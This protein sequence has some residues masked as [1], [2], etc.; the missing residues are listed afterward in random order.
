MLLTP[1]QLIFQSGRQPRTWLALLPREVQLW[2]GH[3]FIPDWRSMECRRYLPIIRQVPITRWM[4]WTARYGTAALVENKCFFQI[5]LTCLF[6]AVSLIIKN[7]TVII[8]GT[9]SAADFCTCAISSIFSPNYTK[10]IWKIG[11]AS[12]VFSFVC[13]CAVFFCAIYNFIFR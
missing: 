7:I 6:S 8:W 13:L 5:E 9:D 11:N 1:T 3:G 12:V 2:R 4:I 10:V